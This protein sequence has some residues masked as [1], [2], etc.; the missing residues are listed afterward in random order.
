MDRKWSYQRVCFSPEGIHVPEVQYSYFVRRYL[1]TAHLRVRRYVYFPPLR[2]Q[3]EH[4]SMTRHFEFV[5]LPLS[6]QTGEPQ[7]MQQVKQAIELY[8]KVAVKPFLSQHEKFYKQLNETLTKVLDKNEKLVPRWFTANAV[9]YGRTVL[10]L[11]CLYL[12]ARDHAVAPAVLTLLNDFGDF[13]DGVLARWWAKRKAAGKSV[14]PELEY[15]AATKTLSLPSTRTRRIKEQYGQFIDAILDKVY[16]VPV[17][18]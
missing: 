12:W 4:P 18:M 17:W 5:L 1:R 8:L 15:D 11:P 3:Q 7:T 2:R 9:T 16:V 13:F 6:V 14:T 10:L